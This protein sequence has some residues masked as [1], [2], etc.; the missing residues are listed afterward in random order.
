MNLAY[1]DRDF[2]YGDPAI[3]PEEPVRGLLSK[4]YARARF[5]GR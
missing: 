1:A 5:A 3:P 2:Y 4:S